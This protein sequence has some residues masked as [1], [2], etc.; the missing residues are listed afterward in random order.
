MGSPEQVVTNYVSRLLQ[1]PG[2]LQVMDFAEG[3][4]QLVA[5]KAYYGGPLVGQD[6]P[7]KIVQEGSKA[8]LSA[9]LGMMQNHRIR[10]VRK[11][12]TIDNNTKAPVNRENFGGSKQ[13][14]SHKFSLEQRGDRK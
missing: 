2:A 13:T 5:V 11:S 3:R 12:P 9:T 14:Q 7:D 1:Y 10:S 4:A 8:E 6:E